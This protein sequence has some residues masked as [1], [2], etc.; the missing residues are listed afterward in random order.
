M[1][2]R[3]SPTTL[4]I[5]ILNKVRFFENSTNLNPTTFSIYNNTTI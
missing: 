1:N 3:V 4:V 5:S 2:E